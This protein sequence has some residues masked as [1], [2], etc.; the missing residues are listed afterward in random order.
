MG[1]V[2]IISKLPRCI[3]RVVM[4]ILRRL[5]YYGRVPY[6]LVKDD[7]DYASIYISNL[8]S[9]KLNAA[10]HRPLC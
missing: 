6:S 4:W 2:K 3:L 1:P 5:D 7:P 9:I 10:Y 8:G